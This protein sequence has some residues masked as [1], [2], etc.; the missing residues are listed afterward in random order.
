[1]ILAA[2]PRKF[3][4]QERDNMHIVAVSTLP[5]GELPIKAYS[6]VRAFDIRVPSAIAARVN[7]VGLQAKHCFDHT[8]PT[9]PNQR[10]FYAWRTTGRE[11]RCVRV[12][13]HDRR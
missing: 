6:E 12:I 11:A 1:M 3:S 10:D 13:Y 7:N 5:I 2:L 4:S 9:D 8:S